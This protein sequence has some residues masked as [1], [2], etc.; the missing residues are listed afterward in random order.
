M[1]LLS[2]GSASHRSA[3]SFVSMAAASS[4]KLPAPSCLS[5]SLDRGGDDFF[6]SR[7]AMVAQP[8]RSSDAVE[9]TDTDGKTKAFLDGLLYHRTGDRRGCLAD[10]D[11]KGSHLTTHLDRVTMPLVCVGRLSFGSY[12][13]EEPIHGRTMHRDCTVAPGL[14]HRGSLFNLLYHLAFGLLALLRGN[15]WSHYGDPPPLFVKPMGFLQ[16]YHPPCVAV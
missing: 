5:G 1:V 7:H 11:E 14:L 16:V 6:F 9:L 4:K 2:V 10:L 12:P 15:R 8:E 3:M 13:F